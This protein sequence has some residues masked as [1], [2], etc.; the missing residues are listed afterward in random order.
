MRPAGGGI[1][2]SEVQERDLVWEHR[3]RVVLFRGCAACGR[4][5]GGLG[6]SVEEEEARSAKC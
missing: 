6:E 4:G 5:R 1:C 3:L 2:E